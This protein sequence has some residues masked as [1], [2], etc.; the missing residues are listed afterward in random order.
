MYVVGDWVERNVGN[1]SFCDCGGGR[2]GLYRVDFSLSGRG[3]TGCDL[4]GGD[5]EV[6]CGVVFWGVINLVFVVWV[7][8]EVMWFIVGIIL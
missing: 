8:G 3:V 7:D 2:E 6:R 1:L 4:V 5:V